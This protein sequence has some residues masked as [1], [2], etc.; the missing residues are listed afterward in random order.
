MKPP[1]RNRTTSTPGTVD[2]PAPCRSS[3]EVALEK[4]RKN[5]AANARV[6]AARLAAAW[7]AEVESQALAAARDKS[8]STGVSRP[9]Q[10]CKRLG[11]S[12]ID[13]SLL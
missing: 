9:K 13:V 3:K 12:V 8:S 6:K 2:L 7:V 5:E 1:P 10:T 4:K 11:A